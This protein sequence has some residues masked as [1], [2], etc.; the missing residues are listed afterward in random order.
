M[1]L[2]LTL[3]RSLLVCMLVSGASIGLYSERVAAQSQPELQTKRIPRVQ[4]IPHQDHTA[5]FLI[6]G[7][8]VTRLHFGPEHRRVFLYPVYASRDVSL[9]RIGHPHDPWGHSH[10]NSVWMSHFQVE[11]VDFWGDRG[12]KVGRVEVASLP[13]EAFQEN[14][15]FASATLH[16]QWKSDTDGVVLLKET[17][18][19]AVHPLPNAKSWLL[20]VDSLFTTPKDRS[21]R[22][23]AT[24]FGMA[25]VRMA[26]TIGVHDGGGRILNSEGQWNE[27]EV[28]RKPAEWV[29]YSG[30][31]TNEENGFGGITLLNH[32]KNPSHPTPFHVRD[33]GWMGACLNMESEI[34]VSAD[35]PLKLRYAYWVHD[36]V[37][38]K[39]A[40]EMTAKTFHELPELELLTPP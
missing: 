26:K 1:I 21:T 25:A 5:A 31:I 29:D 17:R 33:D 16:L 11:G 15:R 12:P 36:G 30:R 39:P 34:V 28:F 10:H 18:A 24:P 40:V 23:G 38:V 2:S 27:K 35:K 13:R 7:R 20:V 22:L 6:E 3:V 8:E 4:V 37:P 32:P 19:V 14:D 9:T